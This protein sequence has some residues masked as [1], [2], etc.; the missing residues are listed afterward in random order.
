M[1]SPRTTRTRCTGCNQWFL[2]SRKV[3]LNE[4]H[5][6]DRSCKVR[7]HSGRARSDRGSQAVWKVC[8]YC[9]AEFLAG[10]RAENGKRLPNKN[11]RF[12]DKVCA[13]RAK[14]NSGKECVPLTPVFA[15]WASGFFDGEGSA[16][17]VV[18]ETGKRPFVEVSIGS[19]DQSVICDLA[20][21]TGLGSPS[22]RKATNSKQ[23]DLYIWR[24]YAGAAISF[25]RQID[26]YL[27]VKRAIVDH[28]FNC[29]EEMNSEPSRAY[30][31]AW[32]AKVLEVSS[33]L[34]ERGPNGAK[35]RLK[36]RSSAVE[37]MFRDL[38]LSEPYLCQDESLATQSGGLDD[39]RGP[40]HPEAIPGKKCCPVDGKEISRPRSLTCSRK[41]A[42]V[43]RK[44]SGEP[45]RLI[46]PILQPYVAG[47]ID[48]EGCI[49]I[50]R[51][52]GTIHAR[53]CFG[54]TNKRIVD[55]MRSITGFGKSGDRPAK[56]K[57]HSESWHW[58]CQCDGAQGFIEQISPFLRIKG[59]QAKLALYVQN[60]L[61]DL[62]SRRDRDWQV[63]AIADSHRLNRKGPDQL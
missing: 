39:S 62:D 26:S 20:R 60:R 27:I 57:Q 18:E 22:C 53:V 41:C 45:C 23:K 54:N 33:E 6:H 38:T 63:Q 52:F 49:S 32:R 7:W 58:R 48:G 24:C 19:T 42:L 56:K 55:L 13:G 21:E 28:V 17:M 11:A 43:F 10:G 3:A 29:Y 14:E 47:L 9:G 31:P 40:E 34:N 44:R 12:C 5:F 30:L 61:S 8:E 16:F 2:T 50:V 51:S 15:R 36:A 59:P 37:R 4:H 35:R 46:H 1:P 25:L